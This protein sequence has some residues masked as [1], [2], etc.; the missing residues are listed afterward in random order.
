MN[1]ADGPIARSVMVVEDEPLVRMMA[2]D[3]FEQAGFRVAE[4]EDSEEALRVMADMGSID[5][6][7]LD[8]GIP[9]EMDGLALAR[10]ARTLHPDAAMLIVSSQTPPPAGALPARARF[11]AKPYD[12]MAVLRALET[13][14]PSRRTA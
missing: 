9:G 7:F 14:L 8:I 10:I 4:A 2:T 3:M 6:L 5:A 12:N 11:I 1:N 13:M